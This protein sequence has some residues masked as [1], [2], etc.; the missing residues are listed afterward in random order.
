MDAKIKRWLGVSLLACGVSLSSGANAAVITQLFVPAQLTNPTLLNDFETVKDTAA[1]T[2]DATG[3]LVSASGASGSTPSGDFGLGELRANEP[4][5]ALLTLPAFEVGMWFGNDETRSF[6][7]ILEVFDGAV[8]LGSVS[9]QSNA[10]DFADQ[11]IGLRSNMAFDRTTIRYQRPE[12]GNLAIYIDD[13]YVGDGA[14][15]PAPEPAT[16]L[17]LGLGLAGLGFARRRQH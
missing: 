16:V 12:A 17:L 9:L 10:N 15:A 2:F 13:F 3:F 11:F 14:P 5:G 4:L 8:S 7:A 6:D 1:V